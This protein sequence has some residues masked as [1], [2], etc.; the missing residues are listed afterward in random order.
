[1]Q[2]SVPELSLLFDSFVDMPQETTSHPQT[3][4]LLLNP[5][6]PVEVVPYQEL[7][8]DSRRHIFEVPRSSQNAQENQPTRVGRGSHEALDRRLTKTGHV[9][10]PPGRPGPLRPINPNVVEIREK[11]VRRSNTHHQE[12]KQN[13]AN[14][15]VVKRGDAIN[16][17][18]NPPNGKGQQQFVRNHTHTRIAATNQL[19]NDSASHHKPPK[20]TTRKRE[21]LQKTLPLSNNHQEAPFQD[22]VL[23]PR[24]RMSYPMPAL[25]KQTKTMNV[26]S[27]HP[28]PLPRSATSHAGKGDP[29]LWPSNRTLVEGVSRTC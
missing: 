16:T 2:P 18:V 20:P 24:R 17:K 6:I 14:Q 29:S 13:V 3:Q 28:H 10:T 27:H 25:Q 19:P 21:I 11:S 9:D 22:E 26:D 23:T 12:V 7:P 4:D 15:S 1:M 8:P 5:T